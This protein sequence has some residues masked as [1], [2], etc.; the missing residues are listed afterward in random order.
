MK[1]LVRYNS[2]SKLGEVLDFILGLP[3]PKSLLPYEIFFI[4]KCRLNEDISLQ[5]L[6]DKENSG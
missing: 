6:H 3:H 5:G 2:I 4:A 1:L